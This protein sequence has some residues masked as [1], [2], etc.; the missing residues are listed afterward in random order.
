MLKNKVTIVLR[1]TIC[2]HHGVQTTPG[3][4]CLQMLVCGVYGGGDPAL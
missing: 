2:S 3:K 1:S 4:T